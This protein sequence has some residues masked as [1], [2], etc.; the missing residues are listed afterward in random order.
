MRKKLEP[1]LRDYSHQLAK[2]VAD[3]RYGGQLL[4]WRCVEGGELLHHNPLLQV[5]APKHLE[6]GLETLVQVRQ[7]QF[8]YV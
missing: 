6:C 8:S 1:D 5:V 2:V 7:I 4:L 3:Q